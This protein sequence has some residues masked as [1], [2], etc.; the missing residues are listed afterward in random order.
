MLLKFAFISLA[1]A[2]AKVVF[3]VPGGPHS[4]VLTI[5]CL[6]TIRRNGFPSPIRCSWPIMSFSVFGRNKA[7]R[8]GNFGS[9]WAFLVG[10]NCSSF[11]AT[12][13]YIKLKSGDRSSS[14]VLRPSSIFWLM[15]AAC[16]RDSFT[17]CFLAVF[18]MSR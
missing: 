13:L 11:R 4:M 16:S 8:G 14:D 7:A 18:I 9:P 12:I 10:L 1:S 17:P 6:S 15:S 3:P 5:F 2:K